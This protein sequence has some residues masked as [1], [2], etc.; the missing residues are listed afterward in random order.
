MKRGLT[1]IPLLLVASLSPLLLLT[2]ACDPDYSLCVVATSCQDGLPITTG[3]HIRIRA[4]ELDG[5]TSS[6]G[7]LCKV[8]LN[9]PSPFEIEADAPGFA[10]RTEG[11]FQLGKPGTTDF[12]ATVCLD[13]L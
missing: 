9:F 6:A 10:P 8:E 7:K 3:A 1:I 13:P 11:P 4:Y 2:T 12:Q 5:T